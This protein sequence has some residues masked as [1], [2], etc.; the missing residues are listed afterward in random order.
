[1]NKLLKPQ[2]N[3]GKYVFVQLKSISEID[4]DEIVCFLNEGETFSIILKEQYAKENNLLYEHITAW[5]TLRINSSL[6]SVGLTSLFSKA[7]ADLKIS[8]NVIAGYKHDHVF[9][10]Y[11]KRKLAINA[12][13]KLKF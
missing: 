8:C 9:V 6:D 12:L 7:L 11:D 2:L 5:I 3:S 1:M 13:K 10:N 4:K